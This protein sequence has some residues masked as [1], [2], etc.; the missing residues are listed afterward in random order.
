MLFLPLLLGN[1]L[2]FDTFVVVGHR[3]AGL[4]LSELRDPLSLVLDPLDDIVVVFWG[5]P[6]RALLLAVVEELL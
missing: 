6:H 4:S 1:Y 2:L 3:V 5:F